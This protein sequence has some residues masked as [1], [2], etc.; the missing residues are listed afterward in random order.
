MSSRY[1]PV[2]LSFLAL[3]ACAKKN[4]TPEPNFQPKSAEEALALLSAGHRAGLEKWKASVF[5]SCD[6]NEALGEASG[7]GTTASIDMGR[8]AATFGDS[9]LVTGTDG[10]FAL[11]GDM[12][13]PAGIGTSSLNAES[14]VNGKTYKVQAEAV[15]NGSDCELKLYGQSV[16]SVR[17]ASSVAL[18]AGWNPA[19]TDRVSASGRPGLVPG[20]GSSLSMLQGHAFHDAVRQGLNPTA[21]QQKLLATRLGLAPEK[22]QAFF[23]LGRTSLGRHQFRLTG[24]AELDQLPA[25]NADEPRIV[26]PDNVT[27]A[28]ARGGVYTL[29]LLTRIEGVKN[30]DQVLNP[31]D[32]QLVRVQAEISVETS[33]LDSSS[34]VYLPRRL[35]IGT[36]E[37]LSDAEA[38]S[39]FSERNIKFAP[40]FR[41]SMSTVFEPSYPTV[42]S[43]CRVLAEDFEGALLGTGTLASDIVPKFAGVRGSRFANYG[44]WNEPL[45][46]G[47]LKLALANRDAAQE[48]DSSRRAPIVQDSARYFAAFAEELNKRPNVAKIRDVFYGM[49]ADWAFLGESVDSYRISDLVAVGDHRR[50]TRPVYTAPQAAPRFRIPRPRCSPASRSR[51]TRA[52]KSLPTRSR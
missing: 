30:R 39:C 43:P 52:A 29:E 36:R 11:L 38:M 13:A 18:A 17:L 47:L 4:K 26:G 41:G 14:T 51:R 50:P 16:M 48:L 8:L 33:S 35:S 40:F 24:Y 20:T 19:R 22:A 49:G 42:A 6:A 25:F 12:T 45:R 15:R 7:G 32:S 21:D 28:L 37:A 27:A 23:P 9:L 34:R 3:A 10:Q 2:V 1:S 31:A 44:G 5:K 46:A